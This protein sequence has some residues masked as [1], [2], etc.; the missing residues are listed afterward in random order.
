VKTQKYKFF[1]ALFLVI[2]LAAFSSDI[3][4][5]VNNS[6]YTFTHFSKH[7]ELKEDGSASAS[8]NLIF[9]ETENDTEDSVD[10]QFVLLPSFLNLNSIDFG[11]QKEF[12]EVDNSSSLFEAIFLSIRVL[13]I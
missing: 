11:L 1:S 3:Y 7:K 2:F 10:P 12:I 9:E 6:L 8:E 4:G 5:S 13:R